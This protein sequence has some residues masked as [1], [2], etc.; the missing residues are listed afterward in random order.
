MG[1]SDGVQEARGGPQ[2]GWEYCSSGID[3]M[4][5]CFGSSNTFCD[6]VILPQSGE[7]LLIKNKE[8]MEALSLSGG[9]RVAVE[10]IEHHLG[11]AE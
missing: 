8:A 7:Q 9:P 10:A 5:S 11:R 4:W 2:E 6:Y 1:T 3:Q